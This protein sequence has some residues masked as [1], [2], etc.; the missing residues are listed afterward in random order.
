M[1]VSSLVIVHHPLERLGNVSETDPPLKEA[2]HRNLVGTVQHCRRASPGGERFVGERQAAKL[3]GVGLEEG[4]LPRPG[5]I[6]PGEIVDREPPGMSQDVRDGNRHVSDPHLRD[7]R[8]VDVLD[9]RM[10]DALRV[11]HHINLCSRKPEEPAR[12]DDFEPLVHERGRVDRDLAAHLPS[13]M[14]ERLLNGHVAQFD[15]GPVEERTPRTGEHDP[16]NIFAPVTLKRLEDRVVLAVD[17]EDPRAGL[18]GGTRDQLAC[19]DEHLLV[20]ERN[21]TAHPKRLQS[22]AK[23]KRPDEPRDQQIGIGNRGRLDQTL[24]AV[25]DLAWWVAPEA[26]AKLHSASGV[27]RGYESRPETTN[28]LG[29]PLQPLSPGERDNL[30]SLREALDDSEGRDTDRAGRAEDCE[31]PHSAPLPRDRSTLQ[32]PVGILRC[33]AAGLRSP[34]QG[35]SS[36]AMEPDTIIVV[37]GLPRSGTSMMM[38]MLEAGGLENLTDGLREADPDNPNGYFELAR[39]TKLENDKDWVPEARGKV[40]KVIAA[41]LRHLPPGEQYRVVFLEREIREVLASQKE[42]LRR[43]GKATDDVPDEQMAT[44]FRRHLERVR[45]WL[46]AQPNFEVLYVEHRDGIENPAAFAAKVAAFLGGSLD[47]CRMAEAVDRSLY[48]QRAGQT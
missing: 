11:D 9:H 7:Y 48:R 32:F 21:V 37:S 17:R 19:N 15:R 13:R 28:L 23:T 41:L 35:V 4:E 22:G 39:V 18:G 3:F 5:Q 6:E 16:A 12:L 26:L 8:T 31:T 27:S 44:H 30:E 43:T 29:E 36:R 46:G 24:D 47:V 14:P 1:R 2:G 33:G 10:D 40:V 45:E 25:G 42:M 34:G 38:G 20:R